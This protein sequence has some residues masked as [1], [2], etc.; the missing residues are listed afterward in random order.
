MDFRVLGP[1]EV[2]AGGRPLDLGAAKQRALLAVLLLHPNQAV[3]AT[4]LIDEIWGASPIVSA[5]K[6]VQGYVSGLRKVLGPEVIVTTAA[7][8]LVRVEP[9]RLDSARFEALAAEG[10]ARVRD[11]PALAGERLREALALWRGR[12]LDGVVLESLAAAEAERLEELR[13]AVVELRVEADLALGRDEV[14]VAE[15][16]ALAGAHPYRERL[17]AQ[18]MLALYRSGRQA[19]A[20]A[21]YRDTRTLLADELGLEPSAELQRLE[22]LMLKQAPELDAPERPAP[23]APSA[24]AAPAAPAPPPASARRPVTVLVARVADSSAPARRLDPEA[25]HALVDRC[26]EL[27]EEAL[28]RHGGA[29]ERDLAD[30]VVAIFGLAEAREDDPLRAARAALEMRDAALA[31]GAGLRIGIEA[32]Q[33]F[34]ASDRRRGS[35]ATGEAVLLAD[36]LSQAA[37]DGEIL[38]AGGAAALLERGV[39]V[40]PAGS[41]AGAWRLRGVRAGAEERPHTGP[42]LGREREL[43]ALREALDAAAASAT[44]HLATVVG[45][46]GLGKSRLA[47][48]FAAGLADRATVAVGRCPPYG[49]GLAYRPLADIVRGLGGEDPEAVAGLVRGDDRGAAVARLVTGAI[50]ASDEPAT[51]EETSWAMR[52]LLEAAARERPLVVVI[53]DAHWAPPTLLDLVEYVAAFSS[54]APILLV[55]LA[56]PEL[57]EAVPSWSAGG[58]RRSIVHLGPLSDSDAEALVAARAGDAGGRAAGIVARAE[59]N[60]LFLEQLVAADVEGDGDGTALPPSLHAVLAGRIDRLPP[61]ERSALARAAVEGRTFHAGAVREL[62]PDDE[63]DG[64]RAALLTLLRAQLVEPDRAEFPGEDAFR[65]AHALIRDVAYEGTPKSLRAD[66]H[67]RMADWLE[68]RP[69]ALDEIIGHHLEQACLHRAELGTAGER[70][71]RIGARGAERLE[72]AARAAL[73]RGMAPAGARL[74]ERA[75]ALLPDDDPSR[76]ALLPELGAALL[77]A[78]RLADAD[79]TLEEATARAAALGDSGLEARARLERWLVRLGAESSIGLAAARRDARAALEVLADRGD[80]LGQCRGWRLLAWVEWTEGRCAAADAAWR[81][82]GDLAGATRDERERFEVLTWR[83]TAAVFGPTPVD[84]GI[85]RCEGILRE[86]A[87]S[88]VAVAATLHPLA[89]LR[90]MLGEFDEARRLLREGNAI[91]RELGTLTAAV[92]HNEALVEML[93]GRPE[94]AEAGLRAGYE[95]LGAMGERALLATTA[96][97]LAQAVLEQGRDEEADRLCRESERTAAPEDLPTQII[98]RGTHARVLARR[99][100]DARARALAAEAVELAERT[101]ILTT[102]AAAFL[103]LAEVHG[104]GGRADEAGAAVSRAFELLDRK[105]CVARAERART[106]RPVASAATETPDDGGA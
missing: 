72:A 1:L 36:R 55:C 104:R 60:P 76:A 37:G 12:P 25:L 6:V 85:A 80:A 3:S 94:A 49:D 56:R 84:E 67:E 97:L 33:V 100:D 46:A 23:A 58:P 103:D 47:H 15:L 52:R 16:Q 34:V 9:E 79:R 71:R 62:L 65:F 69:G 82:A 19:E 68:A 51:E 44:C 96:A 22:R 95:R 101:D 81:R 70:E 27:W 83:A 77:E 4:R 99:G 53:E 88:P 18:L 50:G 57:L 63:R 87:A 8:Y 92:S 74:M 54:G 78:G 14:L 91:L 105:G 66:L 7:G 17:R 86:V 35:A 31:A 48:E 38:V 42:F 26:A 98:W 73:V 28:E 89:A 29:V 10:R 24:P 90:A 40:E 75:A 93:A 41:A 59:G 106:W 20:L 30:G 43:A 61:G 45:A 21:A 5:A 13:L 102:R 39:D 2:T 32:G 64:L 11:D